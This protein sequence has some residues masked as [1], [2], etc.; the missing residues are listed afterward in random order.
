[1]I[2][3]LFRFI[4]VLLLL[5][6]TVPFTPSFAASPGDIVITEIM[7][8]PPES[9]VDSL[10]YIE[11]YNTT[12]SD[13]NL[14]G[15]SISDQDD[16]YFPTDAFIAAHGYVVIAKDSMALERNFGYPDA[17]NLNFDGLANGGERITVKDNNGV[18]LNEVVFDDNAPWPEADGDGPSM[19]L[20]D[21]SSD[22][23]DGANWT[24]ST[25]TT[26]IVI[27]G[28]DLFG[29]P[30]SHDD[31][32]SPP[33]EDT[34]STINPSVCGSYTSPSGNHT[35]TSTGV[36]EDIIPNADFC[37]SLITINL[38][39][40]PNSEFTDINEACESYI[41]ID[42]NTY[43][44][45]N[46]VATY[47]LENAMGCDSIITLDLTILE[48][49]Y[50]TD[51]YEECES[52]I[53]ID[54]NNYTESNF[55][56]THIIENAAG[57]DSI[58]TLD[59]TINENTSSLDQEEA[60]E[61]YTWIDGITYTE[62]NNTAT[63]IIEN[64]AG[65]DSIITL[66]LSIFEN[67]EGIDEIEYC[68]T[69]TWI[70]GITYTES[71]NSAIHMLENAVGC[72]SIVTLN[73]TIL[74]ETESIDSHEECL[75]F[76]WI[77]G[78]T[79]TENNN[80]ATHIVENTA[81]CDSI[82]TLDLIILD[83]LEGVDIVESC[84]SY[85]W[86]NGITYTSNNNIA[87]YIVNNATGCDSVITLNLTI[88]ESS[89]SVFEVE[90]CE[91]YTWIDGN[92]YTEDNFT[93]IHIV[94]N[95]AACD[96]TITL[97]LSI[98]EN[99][100]SIDVV[101]ACES[102]TW[103]DGITYSSSNN[104]ATHIIENAVGCDSII[105]LNL[106]I[107]DNILPV[108]QTQN[109]IVDLNENG[110]VNITAEEI[111]NGS[112][113][114]CGISE[115]QIDIDQFSCDDVGPNTVTL[116]VT[117][118]Q[119]NSS[120]N[121]AIVTVIDLISPEI[122]CPTNQELQIGDGCQVELPDYGDLLLSSDNCGIQ[123]I[124]QNPA[125][126]TVFTDSDLGSHTIGFIINDLQGNSSNCNFSVLISNTEE[127]DIVEI[128]TTEIDC[129]GDDDGMI[130]IITS[131]ASSG[132]F[133]SIDGSDFSNTSGVFNGLM[134][135]T[136]NIYVKNVNGCIIQWPTS[137]TIGQ[138]S[139]LIITEVESVNI[140][141]C[142]GNMNA[143][144]EITASG[145]NAAYQYS[146]N[147]GLSFS[148]NPLFE[149]LNTGE[150]QILIRDENNC[151]T[152][153]EETVIITEPEAISLSEIESL[154]V[155]TCHGEATGE[156]HISAFGGTGIL[157]YSIDDGLTYQLNDGQYFN[158]SAGSCQIKI[159][160]ANDC[161]YEHENPIII[162]EPELLVL[163]NV[164]ATNVSQCNGNSNGKIV[165]SANGGSGEIMYSI[166]GG[167]N[168]ES[169]SGVFNN[170]AAGTYNISII[171]AN[172]CVTEYTQNPVIINEPS[173]LIMSV[174]SSN[175]NTCFG[176]NDGNISI[177]ASGG[178][179]DFSFSINGGISWSDSGEFDNLLAGDYEVFIKDAF[180]CTLEYENNPVHITE[181]SAIEYESVNVTH[182]ECFGGNEGSIHITAFGG[183]GTLSY[184]IDNGA[185]YQ[186]NSD[187]DNL[188][189]SSYFLLMKDANDCV[190]E[191]EN[192]PVI[193]H[194]NEEIQITDAE[195]ND[196]Q[197]NGD[198]GSIHI[199]ASGGAG[200][201]WYS[202]DNGI[203]FQSAPDFIDLIAGSYLVKVKDA[204]DC[205]ILFQGNP[206]IIEDAYASPVDITVNPT[207]GPYCV[208]SGVYLQANAENAMSYQWQPGGFSDQVI[209]VTSDSP[210]TITY[211]VTI[212]N[213]FGCE[214]FASVNIEYDLC[215]QVSEIEHTKLKA[216]I[217]PN[218]NN[219]QFTLDLENIQNNI[220]IVI[221]DFAGRIILE[222]LITYTSEK[223]QK[224]F[225]LGDFENG[226]YF[227]SIKN[228]ESIIYRKVVKQ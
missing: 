219:G 131:G 146:I 104:T 140:T 112:Y 13:I 48:S 129:Y 49:S 169:N 214:S 11:I 133:F 64:M 105:T 65:C 47:I 160:D 67:T 46:N 44:E 157:A 156:I 175:I 210:Q 110:I 168:Y 28:K 145:G 106:S 152:A 224:A 194:Q 200:D 24:A 226:V 34:E 38:S 91:T 193:I 2:K 136:Y 57:C 66:N 89:Q 77:D 52:F 86:R 182:I 81:G 92:T 37:D 114:N 82:I 94:E 4:T 6:G 90:A 119:N 96:S 18:I 98:L 204:N 123:S 21:L 147:N 87:T 17:Y 99:S 73:L 207:T 63:H 95:A 35:W 115:M 97:S 29:S 107:D 108:V 8:N 58:I 161:I 80:T 72:D 176:A 223:L 221:I 60:C 167:I 120:S 138:A 124:V 74:E 202:I 102:Y 61:S 20:C 178:A 85:T 75:S 100:E 198:L 155:S 5:I 43:T 135:G 19:V 27:N 225:D 84:E 83:N 143:S 42:G 103:I 137:V 170:L 116:T 31:A 190:F 199:N 208:N 216:Q 180:D 142:A 41:W 113:D 25:T 148:D 166:D 12:S 53:W 217:F 3:F 134:A 26:G 71:N 174:S 76:T 172:S 126:G 215:E 16:Y 68:E 62:D 79:Y 9:G 205:E 165:V 122:T 56:A 59:L 189:A 184:S 117:D 153:W 187:F 201:L 149:N 222:D 181:P 158:L 191:Y 212:L 188:E 220:E 139:E 109:I 186:I 185:T 164:Q 125:A 39:I 1:M 93:A 36:Y 163:A 23:T 141:G 162:T 218:P 154:N 118:H 197:C 7:Y 209:Y 50:S 101:E 196:V 69:Y 228:G 45:S 159:K 51:V 151:E 179:D 127:F 55:T 132:L 70:D 121:T 171:D 15:F 111:N 192:N 144:I 10:E 88:L 32:C 211:E 183:T 227:L 177:M 54:G 40:L 173:V 22:H 206:I 78:A 14:G 30:G 33:C 195:V 150:Y 128:T 203:N 130:S 213:A